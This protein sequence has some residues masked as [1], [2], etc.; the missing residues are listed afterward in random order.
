[1]SSMQ[2][3]RSGILNQSGNIADNDHDASIKGPFHSSGQSQIPSSLASSTHPAMEENLFL[4]AHQS[5][6]NNK[7][8]SEEEEEEEKEGGVNRGAGDTNSSESFV[9]VSENGRNRMDGRDGM[10]G[11]EAP[12][13]SMK[14]AIEA[15]LKARALRGIV[16]YKTTTD[17]I[18]DEMRYS[19]GIINAQTVSG[20]GKNNHTGQGNF[21]EENINKLDSMLSAAMRPDISRTSR[22][23]EQDSTVKSA[24]KSST[25]NNLKAKEDI[26]ANLFDDPH[27]LFSDELNK[28]TSIASS[29]SSSSGRDAFAGSPLQSTDTTMKEYGRSNQLDSKQLLKSQIQQQLQQQQQQQQQKSQSQ[30]MS[31]QAHQRSA[32]H[33]VNDP[34][35]TS[36]VPQH[37]SS[38]FSSFPPSSYSAPQMGTKNLDSD[39]ISS[40]SIT[41]STENPHKN[42]EFSNQNIPSIIQPDPTV[43]RVFSTVKKKPVKK[44]SL[45]D[46]DPIFGDIPVV[47][48]SSSK[49]TST[50]SSS[51]THATASTPLS[52]S[53]TTLS[54]AIHRMDS[55]KTTVDFDLGPKQSAGGSDYSGCGIRSDGSGSKGGKGTIIPIGGSAQVMSSVYNASNAISS[56][57]TASTAVTNNNNTTTTSNTSTN[58]VNMDADSALQ[59]NRNSSDLKN[60]PAPSANNFLPLNSGAQI[61]QVSVPVPI[62]SLGVKNNPVKKMGLKSKSLFDDDDDDDDESNLFSNSSSANIKKDGSKNSLHSGNV[63][64]KEPSLYQSK[65]S[66]SLFGDDDDEDIFRTSIKNASNSKTKKS[67]E[68]LFDD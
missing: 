23:G 17:T 42:N 16:N 29:K 47:K 35:D 59:E 18:T 7:T 30:S 40:Q 4:N 13:L 27:S 10:D 61:L 2:N 26:F 60:I 57:S 46:D 21:S 1:M 8:R 68:E 6:L 44:A 24:M 41:H 20:N 50:S 25:Q 67:S 36:G 32:A 15:Q 65:K 58:Y 37:T 33:Q 55:N 39:I 45:F 9:T 3:E 5:A 22:N 51:S 31:E 48:E 19:R 63:A 38:N 34:Y 53:T 12:Q 52:A 49:P 11:R 54:H 66:N 64:S 43:S 62:P 56:S 14:D 28:N